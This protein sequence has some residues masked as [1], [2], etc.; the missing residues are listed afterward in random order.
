VVV[1]YPSLAFVQP[2]DDDDN[3]LDKEQK[4]KAHSR[5][6]FSDSSGGGRGGGGRRHCHGGIP[7]N[8][9]EWEDLLREFITS[10]C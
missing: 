10:N 4:P 3:E 7:P 9:A 1:A 6:Q 2:A 8:K 5:K